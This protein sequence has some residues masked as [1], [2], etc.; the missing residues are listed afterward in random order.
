[1]HK[2]YFAL[3][4]YIL[5]KIFSTFI[6]M[7]IVAFCLMHLTLTT[8][9]CKA[10]LC[11]FVAFISIWQNIRSHLNQ[12]SRKYTIRLARF[13]STCTTVKVCWK[14]SAIISA[15]K[16]VHLSTFMQNYIT[17]KILQ[18][19]SNITDN[20]KNAARKTPC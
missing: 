1:M 9:F 5:L 7:H 12:A 4:V 2:Q 17:T 16:D 19:S 8:K 6:N 18:T 13:I 11:W 10:V 20:T 3:T 15:N 14:A